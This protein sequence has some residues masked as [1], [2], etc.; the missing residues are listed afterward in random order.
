MF[1][2]CYVDL[3][4]D[5]IKF[6][7]EFEDNILAVIGELIIAEFRFI[8]NDLQIYLSTLKSESDENEYLICSNKRKDQ[9]F[10]NINFIYILYK[11]KLFSKQDLVDQIIH[12]I[13]FYIN[14]Y[15]VTSIEQEVKDIILEA[16]IKLI[17]YSGKNLKKL[18]RKKRKRKI[19]FKIEMQLAI[20]A[21]DKIKEIHDEDFKVVWP[22]KINFNVNE[23]FFCLIEQLNFLINDMRL[24]SLIE[25]LIEYKDS[26]WTIINSQFG[27]SKSK[28]EIF[29]EN[30]Q[31][32]K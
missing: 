31:M 3:I 23:F 16:L 15:H 5:L 26:N 12:G 20:H 1:S 6:K 24:Q 25:N 9:F 18:K 28:E 21:I 10:G 7:K 22:E 14:N 13:E 32:E 4:K 2:Q 11:N 27:L 17:E 30:K 8:F 29:K 19:E